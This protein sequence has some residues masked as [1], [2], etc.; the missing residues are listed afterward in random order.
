MKSVNVC[1]P[2][3]AA[4]ITAVAAAAGLFIARCIALSLPYQ[5]LLLYYNQL[6]N[7]QMVMRNFSRKV[8]AQL[9]KYNFHAHFTHI[10][11]H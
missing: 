6:L 10:N 2:E 1:K 8:T 4:V 3:Q 9:A 5:T 7:A 11:L